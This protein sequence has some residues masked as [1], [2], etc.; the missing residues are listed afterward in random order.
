MLGAFIIV[1]LTTAVIAMILLVWMV[2][3]GLCLPLC[4]HVHVIII[5]MLTL[6]PALP[7]TNTCGKKGVVPTGI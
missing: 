5:V 1:T 7:N 6:S 2:S 3:R 4:I